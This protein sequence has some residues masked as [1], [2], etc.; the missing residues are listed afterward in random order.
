MKLVFIANICFLLAELFKLFEPL[1][2]KKSIQ[3]ANGPSGRK[4]RQVMDRSF[5]HESVKDYYEYLVQVNFILF[6]YNKNTP[7]ERK[8][9]LFVSLQCN[10]CKLLISLEYSITEKLP[11]T[12]AYIR[13]TIRFH[14]C[15]VQMVARTSAHG[16]TAGSNRKVFLH[17]LRCIIWSTCTNVID[18]SGTRETTIDLRL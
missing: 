2:G 5:S 7:I 8:Q 15:N 11:E 4:R 1:I 16:T 6:N 12:P 9:T 13:L 3:F 18:P 14:L 17:S 10:T